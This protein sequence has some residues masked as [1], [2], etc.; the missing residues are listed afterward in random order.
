MKLIKFMALCLCMLSANVGWAAGKVVV[1]NLQKAML[2][3]EFAQKNLQKLSESPDFSAVNAQYESLRA[4]LETLE[5]EEE[6]KGMTWSADQI[7]EHRKKKEFI[8]ADLELAGKKLQAEQSA[9]ARKVLQELTPKTEKIVK[10]LTQAE[11]IDM[12][13]DS[14]VV[15]YLSTPAVDLTSKVTEQ[16]NKAK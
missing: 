14:K 10:E 16:L 9:V 1:L 15:I 12:V 8:R 6:K 3:T 13:L 4:D 5:K 11:G 2:S 7:T